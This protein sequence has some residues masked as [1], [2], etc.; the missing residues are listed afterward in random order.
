MEAVATFAAKV[1][2]TPREFAR[3]VEGAE[4]DGLH[5]G[6]ITEDTGE[7]GTF[8]TRL[9]EEKLVVEGPRLAAAQFAER[10]DPGV[11]E[12]VDLAGKVLVQGQQSQVT[13]VTYDSFGGIN[14]LSTAL[15]PDD[16]A[17]ANKQTPCTVTVSPEYEI[18]PSGVRDHPD[19]RDHRGPWDR[20][21]IS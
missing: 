11:K 9:P 10:F 18:V 12:R 5:L 19:Q 17:K 6:V 16:L 3:A 21:L 14:P 2:M 13:V 20:P 1:K 4:K 7:F 15:T 8:G